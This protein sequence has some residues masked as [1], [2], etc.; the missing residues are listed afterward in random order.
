MRKTV[1]KTAPNPHRP[2]PSTS[3]RRSTGPLKTAAEKVGVVRDET[4]TVAAK[5]ERTVRA[6]ATNARKTGETIAKDPKRFVEG[7]VR[8][9]RSSLHTVQSDLSREA[10]RIADEV[11]RRVSAVVEPAMRERPAPPERPD[12][13]GPE[14]PRDEGRRPQPEDGPA[15]GAGPPHAGT[16]GG[17]SPRVRNTPYRLAP[18][19]PRRRSVFWEGSWRYLDSGSSPRGGS[20]TPRA[21]P[22][23]RA[24]VCAGG[25]ITGAIYEIGVLA[26]LEERL[27]GF[28]LTE[29]DF[30][31][32][33]SAGSYVGTLVASGVSP[34]VLFRNVTHPR[35]SD[36]D[37][38][39][40]FRPNLGEIA[41][42]V[43]SSPGWLVET[44]RDFY[45]NRPGDDR[46]RPRR[47]VRRPPSVRLL[48]PRRP[49][50]VARRM[51]F[52]AGPHERLPHPPQEAPHRR[53]RARHRRD[54]RLRRAGERRRPDLAGRGGLLRPP[55][56]L[57]ARPDRRGRLHRRRGEEDREHLPRPEGAVRA[58]PLRQPDRPRPLSPRGRDLLPVGREQGALASR[59]FLP[60]LDQVFRLTLHSRLQYGLARYR[61]ERP[62]ADIVLFEPK[63]DELPRLMRNIM[64]TSGRIRIA[65]YAYRS[66]LQKLDAEYAR[67]S[68]VFERHGL[69]LRPAVSVSRSP[70][71]R[72]AARKG[73]SQGARGSTR[74]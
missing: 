73:T 50:V 29:C 64:R 54:A 44:V 42:R 5:V 21:L 38:L 30:F 52:P 71:R 8:D 62:D 49:R 46:H 3:R 20:S 55:G 45:R 63:P 17:L 68:R 6:A 13:E 19:V 48:P 16:Q 25:G 36:L 22:F 53:R 28:S 74:P 18:G 66:T 40:L 23:R 67:L 24:L 10:G 57:P 58:R 1:R 43:V 70:R 34:S 15:P 35:A 32:G 65:E 12:A 37:Q 47:V 11:A 59:G 72:E 14:G 7:V 26:A 2:F 69:R 33:V 31:V 27:D 51:A 60:I 61:R 4:R 56:L 41:S 39:S 9:A